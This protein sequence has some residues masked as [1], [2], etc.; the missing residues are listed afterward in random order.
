MYRDK[1]KQYCNFKIVFTP[2]VWQSNL[3]VVASDLFGYPSPQCA[4]HDFYGNTE[5]NNTHYFVLYQEAK[6]RDQE[7]QQ[8]VPPVLIEQ[9]LPPRN[10][11]S[12][13]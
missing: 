2:D 13:L 7:A 1:K 6:S 5:K 11:A 10:L 12:R 3:A 9:V 4:M 8:R